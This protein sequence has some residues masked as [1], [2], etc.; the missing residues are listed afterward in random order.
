MIAT[1]KVA[2]VEELRRIDAG[3]VLDR[4]YCRHT[5]IWSRHLVVRERIESDLWGV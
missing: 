4:V 2:T 5:L 1:P 3:V